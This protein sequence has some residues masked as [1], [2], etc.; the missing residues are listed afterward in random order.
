LF[1]R[2]GKIVNLLR[3]SRVGSG[4]MDS[5]SIMDIDTGKGRQLTF[6][7]G[8]FGRKENATNAL[9]II[10]WVSPRTGLDNY[11]G[12]TSCVKSSRKLSVSIAKKNEK[13]SLS[14]R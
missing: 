7:L 13:K 5:S 2:K 6:T 9:R 1:R 4:G 12:R 3:W 10:G 11:L 14:L 8:R